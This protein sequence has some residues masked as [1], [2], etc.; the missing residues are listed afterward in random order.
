MEIWKDVKG[1]EGKYQVSQ[2]GNVKSLNYHREGKERILS[3]CKD[4]DGYS[5]VLLY[6]NGQ[7]K[8]CKVHRLVAEAFLR[9]EDN[10]LV[11]NHKDEDKQ[12]NKADNLEFCTVGYNNRY[13]KTVQVEQCDLNGN[14][15]SRWES[16]KEAADSLNLK[17]SNIGACCRKYGRNKTAGGYVWRYAV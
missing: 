16:I 8:T 7:K 17:A 9:T 14:V 10:T 6:K 11:I 5:V 3:K 13:S 15:I 12:N 1:Y 2:L 4:K